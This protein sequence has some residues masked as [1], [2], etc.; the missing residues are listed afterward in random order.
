MADG[1]DMGGMNMGG[2]SVTET[3]TSAASG[4]VAAELVVTG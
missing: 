3:G 2:Q 1:T 4:Q